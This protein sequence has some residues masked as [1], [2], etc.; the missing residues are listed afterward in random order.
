MQRRHVAPIKVLAGRAL[1][2][3]LFAV[4]PQALL[5]TATLLLCGG[6]AAGAGTGV[7]PGSPQGLSGQ[8]NDRPLIGPAELDEL[9]RAFADRYVGLLR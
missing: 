5:W 3:G 7:S 6:C 8:R 2:A 1:V 4:T 9:T